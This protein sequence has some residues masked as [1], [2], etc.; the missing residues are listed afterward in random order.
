MTTLD[1]APVTASARHSR[2]SANV[3]GLRGRGGLG[4]RWLL[5]IGGTLLPLG[6]ILVL[7][8]W[9]GAAST[10]LVFE[11]TSYLISGGLLGLALV[12]AGGFIYFAYWLTLLVRESRTGRTELIAVLNRVEQLLAEGASGPATRRGTS[13]TSLVATRNG[14]MFHRTD[15]A[16]VEGKEGLRAVTADTAGLTACKLCNPV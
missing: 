11:Q 5:V 7:L 9:R 3:S 13:L 14:T 16:A 15:C 4:D 6:V 8:G 10:P 12:F 2:L 1:S